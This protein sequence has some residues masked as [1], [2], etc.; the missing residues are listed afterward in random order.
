MLQPNG[1]TELVTR[2]RVPITEAKIIE[3]AQIEVHLMF[4]AEAS[5]IRQVGTQGQSGHVAPVVAAVVDVIVIVYADI[6]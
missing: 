3:V 1:M 4:V 5:P 2:N 6:G